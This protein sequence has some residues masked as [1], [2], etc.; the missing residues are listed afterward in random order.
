VAVHE[1]AGRE[2]G[3]VGV[4]RRGAPPAATGATGAWDPFER[5]Y[6]A[7]GTIDRDYAAKR[8]PVLVDLLRRHPR[9]FPVR[10]DVTRLGE[11]LLEPDATPV[12]EAA[13]QDAFEAALR[14]FSEHHL[15]QLVDTE[16]QQTL[17]TALVDIARDEELTRRDRAGAALGVA[18]LSVPPDSTGLRGRGVLDLVLRVTM[19][20]Q[21]AQE[22]LRKKSR[23]TEGGVPPEDLQAFWEQHPALRWQH[24]ERYRREVTQVLRQ[25]E[26]DQVPPAISVDL[27]L[28]GASKLLAAVA[29]ARREGR[30]V[31][32]REAEEVLKAPFVQDLLDGGAQVVVGR[33]R[34]EALRE[35]AAPS[36]ERRAL[37]RTVETA[38]RLVEEQGPGGDVVLFYLYMRA[39][40]QGHYHVR[41]DAE[42][43]AAKDVFGPAGLSAEGTLAYAE[44]LT[45]RGDH[46]SK[47]RVIMAAL[48]LWPDHAGV[49]EAA[50][51]MGRAEEEEARKKRL[52]PVYSEL[53]EKP[54]A[55]P[56]EEAS[57]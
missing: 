25:I 49:R 22:A 44:H 10:V 5:V 2:R 54:A 29:E 27:A 50:E 38:T 11:L 15:H 1:G 51:A 21:T 55:P 6:T 28:R 57:A 13:T 46:A 7:T 32:A 33:W 53:V 36:D 18:L 23:E 24:E 40:V 31:E 20:E 41:D 12:R 43:Q 4:S 37:L 17:G 30:Q 52:G 42:L 47:H 9:C 35:V 8:L 48:E 3:T 39:V 34:A 14:S 56:D 16:L 19:E 45:A 26:A